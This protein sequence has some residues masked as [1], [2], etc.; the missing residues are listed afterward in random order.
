M[1]PRDRGAMTPH[2]MWKSMC[3]M[4]ESKPF[5]RRF[6]ADVARDYESFAVFEISP[7]QYEEI[8][9]VSDG[10]AY[11]IDIPPFPFPKMI[12]LTPEFAISIESPQMDTATQVLEY[13]SMIHWVSIGE[14]SGVGSEHEE[15]TFATVRCDVGDSV[16]KGKLTIHADDIRSQIH[17]YGDRGSFYD[18]PFVNDDGVNPEFI[19]ARNKHY[20]ETSELV[21]VMFLCGLLTATW[22]NRPKHYIVEHGPE[23]VRKDKGKNSDRL[24]RLGE[25][26]RYILL[27]HEDVRRRWTGAHGEHGSPMPHLRRGHFKTLRAERYGDNRGK[28]I[29]VSPCHVNGACVEWRQ[30]DVRYKVIG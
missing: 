21:E 20:E 12:M 26:S 18:Y 29:W 11:E 23:V 10:A 16:A 9:S 4:M 13:R 7:D 6:G 22:I 17:F 2:A 3:R 8:V 1:T 27:D 14:G 24:P 19:E 5:V 25:R 28:V 30:G 15:I